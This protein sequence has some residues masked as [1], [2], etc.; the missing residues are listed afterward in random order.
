M[1]E[2][3]KLRGDFLQLD[4]RDLAKLALFFKRFPLQARAATAALLNDLS[5]LWRGEAFDAIAS[6]TIIRNPR[7]DRS[8]LRVQKTSAGPIERQQAFVGSIFTYA[9]G[10]RLSHDGWYSLQ[11]GQEPRT[12]N[13]VMSLLARGGDRTRPVLP[14]ARLK[15]GTEFPK[16]RDWDEVHL[17]QSRVQAMIRSM[18]DSGVYG[19]T[20]LLPK[21]QSGGLSP[22]LYKIK[23]RRGYLLPS[24]GRPAPDVAMLQHFGKRPRGLRFAWMQESLKRL[25]AHAPIAS[26]W[27]RAIG[28]AM[29]R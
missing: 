13:R 10:G 16:P 6:R 12:R 4:F 8:R 3:R 9:K 25:I 18:A 29:G 11:T 19:K 7:F 21:K 20:F 2:F 26:M 22:G 5:F 28:R 23:R 17:P 27:Q 14:S 15:P 24:T 1:G